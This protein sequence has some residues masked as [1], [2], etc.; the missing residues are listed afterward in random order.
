MLTVYC[1][2]GVKQLSVDFL[3]GFMA[4]N[5]VKFKVFKMW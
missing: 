2:I 3:L 1:H 4:P 5:Q